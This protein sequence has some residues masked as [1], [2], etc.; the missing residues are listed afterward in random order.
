MKSNKNRGIS[1]VYRLVRKGVSRG[2]S[3]DRSRGIARLNHTH[4][5]NIPYLYI[6]ARWFI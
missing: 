2:L 1:M 5:Y 4:F 6:L 3:L